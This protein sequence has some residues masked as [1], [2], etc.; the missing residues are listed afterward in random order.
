MTT[1]ESSPRKPLR[2]WPGVVLAV[3]LVLVGYVLPI[4][5]PDQAA[6]GLIGS[7]ITALLIILWWLILSRARWVERVGGLV[8][9]IAAAIAQKYVVHPS[10]AGGGMGNMSYILAVPTLTVALVIWAAASR[11]L[12]PGAR[13][14]AA[15]VA[16]VIGCLPWML[17]RTGGITAGGKSDFHWRW[18]KTPEERLLALADEPKTPPP[19]PPP[20]ETPK[21]SVA[22]PAED[23]SPTAPP[24]P[25]VATTMPAAHAASTKPAE[26]P[27]FR[28]PNRDS[29][30][31]G[32][33]IATD[34]SASPPVQIWRRPVGPGWSS[35]AV[36]GNLFYTQEQ[37]GGDEVVSCY[38]MSNGEAVWRHR[39][40]TRFYESN[41][42][43]GP[44]GT[45]TLSNGRVY[46]LG[47]TG[48]L[49]V[50]DA[51]NGAVV[52][53]RNAATDVHAKI[54]MWGISSSPLVV[55]DVV[56]VAVGGKL[57]AY[58]AAN[59]NPRWSGAGSGFSY[60]S[61]Q[62]ATIQG[63]QQV[64]FMSGP[65]TTSVVPATG[66][67]LWQHAWEGG[68]ITQP[69][70]TPDG[71]VLVNTISMNGGVGT[72]RLSVARHSSGWTVEERWTSNGLKPYFNDFVVHK[73]HAYGFD[74]AILSCVDLEDG[75][76]LWKGGRY[77]NGQLLLIADQ[78]LLLV[79]SEEGELALVKATPDQFT[80]VARVPA[81][82]S[83][84]WN[85]PVI[86]GDVLLVRNGE[87]MVAYRLAR[88][89]GTISATTK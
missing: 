17:V 52:W 25:A 37:R 86:V 29:V 54:P 23:K 89:G 13:A 64:I 66:A 82:N 56:I 87:E 70:L 3:L 33:Q 2:L 43:A 84:T 8:L 75:K 40:A 59:G 39:D 10:V 73:G 30:V 49:N 4:V 35:F 31:H 88:A 65:G 44:R 45:P 11:R 80:E 27:G 16:I 24:A 58:D 1:N 15:V 47:A 48:I 57:A 26:W 32:T 72:R 74:G 69:V 41:G 7:A 62:L 67:V 21:P 76:R 46:T 68:A 77:G 34:W 81:L 20:V 63:V 22:A 14:L 78:D 83:K 61:P 5:F 6:I 53:S 18:T 19:A 55:D 51:G 42:G 36:N 60:S 12:A 71:G 38:R 50:L 85:H 28:G 79:I 9:L